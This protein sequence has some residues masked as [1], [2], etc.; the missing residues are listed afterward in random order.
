MVVRESAP[1][2]TPLSKVMAI[3]IG[4]ECLEAVTEEMEI[5]TAQGL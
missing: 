3:L 4:A 2:M 5:D 1:S